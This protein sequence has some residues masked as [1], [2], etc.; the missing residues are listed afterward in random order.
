[1]D[2]IWDGFYTGQIR[3]S[4]WPALIQVGS[5][6]ETYTVQYSG[7]PPQNQRFKLITDSIYG[8]QVDIDYTKPGVYNLLDSNLN[9]IKANAWNDTLKT[10]NPLTRKYCGENR[11]VG[12][13]NVLSFW[14]TPGCLISIVPIDAIASSVRMDWTLSEFYADGGATTF[15]DRMASSLGIQP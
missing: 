1:M 13:V 12:V 6:G 9:P 2:H 10:V 7:T 3:L 11:Y 14:I 4:R 15:S 5:Q 8:I